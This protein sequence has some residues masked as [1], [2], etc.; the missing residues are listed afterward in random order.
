VLAGGIQ[1]VV[2][3]RAL[4]FGP[5]ARALTSRTFE[6]TPE[7]L[8]RG[9]AMMPWTAYSGM[10]DEDLKAIY[11]YLRTRKPVSHV[12]A[13]GPNP[14]QPPDCRSRESA[15]SFSSFCCPFPDCV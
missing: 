10:T 3:W 6:A 14:T 2:G 11:A 15:L 1:A 13:N 9:R 5:K 4:L 7:R 12:V 8:E